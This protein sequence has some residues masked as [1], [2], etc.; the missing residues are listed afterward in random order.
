MVFRLNFLHFKLGVCYYMTAG[1]GDG[2]RWPA[3][4]GRRKGH[5]LMSNWKLFCLLV[6]MAGMK[7]KLVYLRYRMASL[8]IWLE[9][10]GYAVN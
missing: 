6:R 1:E 9:K 7:V 5:L 8:R 10:N 4:E 3:R 2:L